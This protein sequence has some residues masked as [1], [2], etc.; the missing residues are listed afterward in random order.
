MET[1]TM[2]AAGTVAGEA[3]TSRVE[4]ELGPLLSALS[5][6]DTGRPAVNGEPIAAVHPTAY[7]EPAPSDP[8]AGLLQQLTYAIYA[9]FHC[10]APGEPP[11]AQGAPT[12]AAQWAERT[13]AYQAANRGRD[14]WD[15]GWTVE[16]LEPDGAVRLAKGD[17]RRRE[18][19]GRFAAQDTGRPWLQPGD[20][21]SVA[22]PSSSTAVQP[23]FFFLL[24][25]RA[26]SAD[27][28]HRIA[29]IYWN[30][31]AEGAE[32]WIAATS[33]AL[34]RAGL[35]FRAKVL[36]DPVGFARCDS[37]VLYLARRHFEA[38]L[39]LVREIAVQVGDWLGERTPPF[40][41]RLAPGV[42]V[43]EDPGE[44]FGLHRARLVAEGLLAA[45][46]TGSD[47]DR[48]RAVVDAFRRAGL[49]PDRPYLN[50]GNFDRYQQHAHHDLNATI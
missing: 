46:S 21:V 17:R 40:T 5:L 1:T 24:G 33:H 11:A 50:P 12:T 10:A 23:G 9:R 43:A 27:D 16:G 35:P 31:S 15:A 37:A 30:L 14:G 2:Q 18:L 49:D 42:A 29:R 45:R 19:P 48:A 41:L 6:D 32:P 4:R 13:R 28:E 34:Q 38:C 44:S 36:M 7:G 20:L 47:A 3:G 8:Q 22:A 25:Q 26:G 39:P